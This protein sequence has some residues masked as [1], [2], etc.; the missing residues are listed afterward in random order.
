MTIFG[1]FLIIF[2][3]WAIIDAIRGTLSTQKKILWTL[4]IILLPMLGSIL[5][6]LIG[7]TEV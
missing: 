4:L 5:Y 7:K 3:I 6:V 2:A 1:L